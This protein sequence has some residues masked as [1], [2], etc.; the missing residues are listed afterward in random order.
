MS[1]VPCPFFL[2]AISPPLSR[3]R[4][5]CATTIPAALFLG[6]RNGHP[7]LCYYYIDSRHRAASS[8]LYFFCAISKAKGHGGKPC[9]PH[10]LQNFRD[11]ERRCNR[12]SGVARAVACPGETDTIYYF[13]Y[14]WKA[15]KALSTI[16]EHGAMAGSTLRR[17][18]SRRSTV[19]RVQSI[20]PCTTS[21]KAHRQARCVAREQ[22]AGNP[23]LLLSSPRRGS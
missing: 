3:S 22:G 21:R 8:M 7:A 15:W 23:I 12:S 13:L 17:T 16:K 2:G 5:V 19:G 20:T 1:A 18:G 10:T 11:I 9:Q 14:I 4:G 6:M